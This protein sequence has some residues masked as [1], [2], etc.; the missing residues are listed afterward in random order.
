[1]ELAT[2][3]GAGKSG[4][5]RSRLDDRG[6]VM[7]AL[8]IAM[9][10]TAIWL[11]TMLPAWRQQAVR[12]R[13]DDLIF[14]GQQYGRAIALYFLNNNCTLPGDVDILVSR[15]YLR[16]KWKDPIAND[17]FLPLMTGLGAS[18]PAGSGSQNSPQTPA[19]PTPPATAG[20]QT[21]VGLFGVSSKST[22]SS[23]KIYQ[24][25]QQY[26]LW[27]FRYTDALQLMGRPA[28]CNNNGQ[29]PGGQ[30][31]GPGR[32]GPPGTGQQGTGNGPPISGGPGGNGPRPQGPP[33]PGIGT[34]PRPGPGSGAGS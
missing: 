22:D 27:A 4:V 31:G 32:P 15:H 26:S 14:R 7:V 28:N 33:P 21:L 24:N 19:R 18:S 2:V 29:N 13:E 6:F 25:Q 12:Q 16:K 17:D 23:I 3:A 20:G 1:M 30:P 5:G 11:G 10:I 34:G 9:A 8:L